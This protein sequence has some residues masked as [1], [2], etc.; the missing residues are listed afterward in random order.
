MSFV[1][2]VLL[3]GG[4]IFF[5]ELGHFLV[6]RM[7]GVH[8]ET[9]SIGF[10]PSLF[11]IKGR[12]R[13]DVPPT[14]Y[15]IAL[16]P[17]GGYVKMLGDDPAAELPASHRDVSFQSKPIWR[18][19]AIVT[20]G[21]AFNLILPYFIFFFVA[22]AATQLI[23]SVVGMV[24]ATGAA[25]QAGLRSGDTVISLDGQPV[26]YWWQLKQTVSEQPGRALVVQVR[27]QD[28]GFI[29]TLTL[30]PKTL[31][32][33]LLP[34]L[35]SYTETG[36]IGVTPVFL[37]P[38]VAVVDGSPAHQAGLESGDLVV[39][40]NGKAVATYDALRSEIARLGDSPWDLLL[41]RHRLPVDPAP[42]QPVEHDDRTIVV[43]PGAHPDRGLASWDCQLTEVKPGTPAADLGLSPGDVVL[44]LNGNPCQHWGFLSGVLRDEPDGEH[45]LVWSHGSERLLARRRGWVA[46]VVD[47]T[48]MEPDRTVKTFGVTT[49]AGFFSAPEPVV[50]QDRFTF[51]LT[52]AVDRTHEAI[53]MNVAAIAG[54]FRGKVPLTEL[55]GPIGIAQLAARTS[56]RGWEYFFGLMVWLSI[57]LGLINLLPI[58]VL[59]GG[60]ILFL[61]M[62]AVRR[63]PVSLRTR[64]IA[65]YMGLAF[66]ILLMVLVIKNDIERPW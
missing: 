64:Q 29:E 21:P 30:T 10:G 7:M 35:D 28:T 36:R 16:L 46:S 34:G 52:R 55:S 39:A 18:R 3:L 22:L 53:H 23:P 56:E 58:P 45:T 26:R 27:R 50:N 32:E 38:F 17:L 4:L 48:P 14:E 6:A 54:L 62:E 65:T 31:R 43:E 44:S 13:G 63:K 25:A 20:A 37:R 59:D 51:A 40:I 42:S 12:D 61:A 5:H 9:F 41:R 24:D 33:E 11:T 49:R 66:I 8:V 1:Y 57:S 2:F 19:L 60:H 15:V 47:P